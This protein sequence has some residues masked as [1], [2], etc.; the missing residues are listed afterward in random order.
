MYYNITLTTTNIK[1]YQA[2]STGNSK[3]NLIVYLFYGCTNII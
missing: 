2:T 3:F 1:E